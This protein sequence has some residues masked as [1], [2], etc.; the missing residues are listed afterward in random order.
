MHSI[1]LTE[2]PT[3]KGDPRLE[4]LRSILDAETNVV[5]EHTQ[6]KENHHL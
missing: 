2:P 4:E 3:S 6:E 5:I 1:S